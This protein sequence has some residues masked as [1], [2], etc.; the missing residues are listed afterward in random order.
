MKGLRLALAA[1]LAVW[2]ALAGAAPA[3]EWA[4]THDGGGLYVDEARL[5]LADPAGNLVLAGTS[6]DGVDGLDMLALKLAKD[7]GATLW[8]RRQPSFDG[9]DMA[10]SALS[11]D[12]LGDL[13]LVGYVVGCVG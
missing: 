11:W 2:P 5:A 13:L 12:G 6:H 8:E 9:N 10:V 1:A 7:T 4:A 3:L